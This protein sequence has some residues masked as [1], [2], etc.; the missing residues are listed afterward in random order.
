VRVPAPGSFRVATD[1]PVVASLRFVEGEA[2]GRPRPFDTAPGDGIA[3]GVSR[4][5]DLELEL[6]AGTT[7][8]ICGLQAAPPSF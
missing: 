5:T 6:P 8:T 4:P 7:T 1:H 2:R 3:I